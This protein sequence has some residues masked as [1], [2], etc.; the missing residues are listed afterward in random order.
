[1][2]RMN[3]QQREA[4]YRLLAAVEQDPELKEES[5]FYGQWYEHLYDHLNDRDDD[6]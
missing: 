1:M 6:Q 5:K 2:K 4:A 3:Q